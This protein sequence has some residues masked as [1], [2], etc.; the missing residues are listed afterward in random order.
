MHPLTCELLTSGTTAYAAI[1]TY[2]RPS[3]FLLAKVYI[4]YAYHDEQRMF[5]HCSIAELIGNDAS[6]VT[7]LSSASFRCLRRGESTPILAKPA[8]HQF[9]LDKAALLTDIQ[10][11]QVDYVFD[12][13]APF[14]S[15]SEAGLRAILAETRHFFKS[16]LNDIDNIC[17]QI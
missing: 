3:S 2:H 13:P 8:V 17:D 7:L 11:W 14:V 16:M 10:A 1:P 12:V 5:Y 15:A 9:S 4:D 6:L